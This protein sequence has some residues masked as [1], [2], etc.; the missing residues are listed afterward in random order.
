[1]L[2][3][4]KNQN[5][6]NTAISYQNSHWPM[7]YTGCPVLTN[8]F[9]PNRNSEIK[10]ISWPTEP[11]RV[12]SQN[13]GYWNYLSKFVGQ[14]GIFTKFGS[15]LWACGI[16]IVFIQLLCLKGFQNCP[17]WGFNHTWKP[18]NLNWRNKF[19]W[20]WWNIAN[21]LYFDFSLWVALL[22]IIWT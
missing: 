2:R 6:S 13:E 4:S 10:A 21:I 8:F 12:R 18:S 20:K 17:W 1:M 5:I 3:F 19:E 7:A 9:L 22:A 15:N 16:K 11:L 14:N